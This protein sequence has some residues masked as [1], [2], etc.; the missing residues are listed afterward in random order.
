VAVRN[1]V[2]HR[3]ALVFNESKV[4]NGCGPYLGGEGRLVFGGAIVWKHLL[5]EHLVPIVERIAPVNVGRRENR[6]QRGL[7]LLRPIDCAGSADSSI[8]DLLQI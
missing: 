7:L 4:G 8:E 5:A 1:V 2:Q 6:L 3:R